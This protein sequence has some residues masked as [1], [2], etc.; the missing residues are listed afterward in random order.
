MKTI[1]KAIISNRNYL[2]RYVTSVRVKGRY[3]FTLEELKVEFDLPN[4]AINQSLNRLKKKGDIAQ[5]RKG[6]YAIIPPEYS[7]QKMLPPSLFI[8]DLMKSLDKPYYV[9]LLSAAATYGAAHQQPMEYFVIAETPAPRSIMNKKLKIVFLSKND[10]TKD[11]INQQKTNAGYINVS[12]P[13][14]T[15]LDFSHTATN[16]G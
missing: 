1:D 11:G 6:F 16:W 5:V 4:T 13:E 7:I 14:L 2:E 15:A 10:W 3:T 12:S 8:D 9:A